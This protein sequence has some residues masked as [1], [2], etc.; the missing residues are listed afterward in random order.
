MGSSEAVFKRLTE[1]CEC[2]PTVCQ[3]RSAEL[4]DRHPISLMLVADNDLGNFP[5]LIKIT[6]AWKPDWLKDGVQVPTRDPS[7]LPPV[8]VKK[9]NLPTVKRKTATFPLPNKLIR[10]TRDEFYDA[11]LHH[12]SKKGVISSVF[13]Q[14]DE[15]DNAWLQTVNE[16]R[17]CLGEERIQDWMIESVFETAEE[18]AYIKSKDDALSN[19]EKP[20]EFDENTR[21]DVCLSYEGEDGNELV[22]CDG[23]L[24]CVHQACYGIPTLPEGSWL[25]RRCEMGAKSTTRCALCPN[26]GGAMKLV[27]DYTSW[28]HVSCALWVPE[29]AFGDIDLMEPVSRLNQI[30]QARKNLVCCLC[31]LRDG[32]PIQCSVKKCKTA[33]HVTCAFQGGLVMLQELINGDVRLLAHCP[34]HSSKEYQ[35][36]LSLLRSPK[37]K[38]PALVDTRSPTSTPVKKEGS[39]DK[40]RSHSPDENSQSLVTTEDIVT[41]LDYEAKQKYS[42]KKH[43]ARDHSKP[44][45]TPPLADVIPAD[46][47]EQVLTYWRIKRCSNFNQPL[48]ETP[49]EW[50]TAVL[51]TKV[52]PTATASTDPLEE[53]TEVVNRF[54]RVRFGLDRARMVIDMVL[55][56]E[57][58]KDALLRK[59]QQIA[60]IQLGVIA[61]TPDLTDLPADCL[62]VL[63]SAHLGT[64]VY[65]DYNT[66]LKFSDANLPISPTRPM[67]PDVRQPETRPA[68]TSLSPV[69]A[70][71]AATACAGYIVT[72]NP[73][74]DSLRPE[75][76][77]VSPSVLERLNNAF[78]KK[79]RKKRELAATGRRQTA[80]HPQNHLSPSLLLQQQQQHNLSGF[81]FSSTSQKALQRPLVAAATPDYGGKHGL[82]T[83][84]KR[85]AE[86]LTLPA[87]RFRFDMNSPYQRQQQQLTL[88]S[89]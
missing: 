36:R 66:L 75:Q 47:I 52:P 16:E 81:V 6:N 65:E 89:W 17:E 21:C 64:S 60:T 20:I 28:C 29:V 33:F 25:C 54:K 70:A 44:V 69:K 41:F 51:P 46:I 73:V 7:T 38:E 4:F 48:M 24:V 63:T 34:K 40:D 31:R 42:K 45:N 57:R 8:F 35:S 23:C 62:K 1:I 67:S 3:S 9:A 72:G 49:E 76:L 5:D 32:A 18:I 37:K 12:V 71:A 58:R 77:I 43:V 83:T 53:A 13:Y 80:G 2:E 79:R 27:D 26:T 56:R 50:K 78:C 59:M 61:S 19:E 30:P 88:Q 82:R 74:I 15:L 84:V 22:F 39:L 55:Q 87:K 86:A 14:L 11:N 68:T 85:D 10:C